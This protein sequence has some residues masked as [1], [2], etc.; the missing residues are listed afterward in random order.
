MSGIMCAIA[1]ILAGSASGGVVRNPP[2][3]DYYDANN[4]VTFTTVIGGTPPFSSYTQSV[5]RWGG[6]VVYDSGAIPYPS[7]APTTVLVGAYT[8]STGTQRSNAGS[9]P[10]VRVS[11][12]YREG[13]P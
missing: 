3:G 7:N 6:V 4:L 11:G 13:P 9:D 5:F 10:N 12:I 2:T 1:G 8:Y